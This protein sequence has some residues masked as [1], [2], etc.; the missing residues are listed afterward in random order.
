MILR[1]ED[2]ELDLERF[3]LR[4]AGE[5]VHVE[6]QVFDLIAFLAR[7]AGSVVL[8]DALVEAVW[9]GLA[10]SDATINARI[11]GARRALGDSGKEQRIIRTVPRKGFEFRPEVRMGDTAPPVDTVPSK[12]SRVR[13]VASADGTPIAWAESGDGPVLIRAS[14]W[15]SHLERDLSCPL[16]QPYIDRLSRYRR[17][18]RYDLRGTGLSGRDA[19]LDRLDDFVNDLEAVADASGAA[20]VDIFA[21][22]QG[23]PVALAYAVRH[24]D[25]LR[26][27]VILGGYALGRVFRPPEPGAA[28]EETIL[29]MIR[30]GWGQGNSAF[31]RAFGALFIP[32]ATREEIDSQ[33]ATQAATIAPDRA[34]ELRKTVDRFDVTGLLPDVRARTLVFHS[35][36]DAIHP[37]SQG[38]RIAAGVPGAE[39]SRVDSPNHALLPQEP[40]W[41]RVMRDMERFLTT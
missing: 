24:P 29:G 4:R 34:V 5:T 11:S 35:T 21:C 23:A 6:P 8:K 36:G 28:D 30:A 26:K 22:S 33:I 27:L 7:N 39:F 15:L 40:E 31:V 2:C 17:L 3:V 25:R 10:V 1:F 14:H 13:Y 41:E 16:W 19:R 20:T 32:E 9:Q 12:A 18:L 37:I 38:Q